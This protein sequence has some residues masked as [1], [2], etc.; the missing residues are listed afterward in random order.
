[1]MDTN[2]I[3]K[4]LDEVV[5]YLN[6]GTITH[7]IITHDVPLLLKCKKDLDYCKE[8]L[9]RSEKENEFLRDELRKLGLF[10]M[11]KDV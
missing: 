3:K 1:M 4:R 5:P 6:E 11:E 7:H 2:E 10:R 8:C 9:E